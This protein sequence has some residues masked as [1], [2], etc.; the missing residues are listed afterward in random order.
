[1][2][3]SDWPVALLNGSYAHVFSETTGAIRSVAGDAADAILGVNARR[4][5]GIA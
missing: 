4:L 1:M 5:Y 2:F 3:G